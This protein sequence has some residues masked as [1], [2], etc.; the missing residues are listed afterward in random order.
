M[1]NK[2]YGAVGLIGGTDGMLDDIDGAALADGDG[3]VVIVNGVSYSYWL[4]DDSAAAE[5]VPGVIEPDA[6]GGDKR[7]IL[8]LPYHSGLLGDGTAGRVVRIASLKIEDG[9]NADTIKCTLT[10]VWNGNTI[11]VTDNIGK[12]ATTGNFYLS[13]S[14]K[15][16]RILDTGLTGASLAAFNNLT[17]HDASATFNPI[18]VTTSIGAGP[19]GIEVNARTAGDGLT[20]D[21]PAMMDDGS[22]TSTQITIMYITD[23]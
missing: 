21:L 7:W 23:A 5:S 2:F 20:I 11:S 22:I 12:G 9:T 19:A 4:D 16:L 1:A 10:D 8:C 15:G 18:F 3:A 14:G 6:N 13:A 17:Y